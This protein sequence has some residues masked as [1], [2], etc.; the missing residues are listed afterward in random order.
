MATKAKKFYAYYIAERND[1]GIFIS[2]D[3][4]KNF[5]SGK[6]NIRYKSFPTKAEAEEWLNS[7]AKYEPNPELKEKKLLKAKTNQAAKERLQEGIYFDSGTG[8]GIG[9]EV[10]VTDVHGNSYLPEY[11]PKLTNEFGNIPLGKDVTNNYGELIGLYCALKIA[12][13]KN[14][15][16]IYGD[17]N[18]VIHYW[19]KGR[20][21]V[22]NLNEKTV[23]YI[24]LVTEIRKIF[25]DIG[26]H[27]EF[28]SG[29]INP[30]DLGFH[31]S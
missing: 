11:F 14:I 27:V 4:C 12:S 19:S 8:R 15:L 3:E 22:A 9:V 7:G 16:N 21:N 23:K 25:E 28:V 17:S 2:W 20:A 30:S 1:K 18:L 6:K 26:G 29:D 5:I 10:R 13:E 24:K 31:K